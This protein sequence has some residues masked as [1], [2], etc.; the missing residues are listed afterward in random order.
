M[1]WNMKQIFIV[2]DDYYMS[3]VLERAF[4]LNGYEVVSVADG[5]DAWKQLETMT[6]TPAA[7][8]AD[9]R[10]PNMD[11]ITLVRTIRADHRF[12]PV[13]VVIVTNSFHTERANECIDAGAD[14]YV[15]KFDHTPKEIVQV[16][17]EVIAEREQKAVTT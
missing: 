7:I 4:R 9:I 10:M 17:E 2:E 15:V 11:G 1:K 3:R 16:A 5:V 13:P 12:D 14:R 6:P 8:F